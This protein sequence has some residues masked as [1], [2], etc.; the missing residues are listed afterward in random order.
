[1]EGG[2]PIQGFPLQFLSGSR[3]W[4]RDERAGEAARPDLES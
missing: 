1:M 2:F 3:S 4:G